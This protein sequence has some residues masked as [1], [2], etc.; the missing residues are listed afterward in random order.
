MH[1]VDSVVMSFLNWV[2][3]YFSLPVSEI[4]EFFL[5]LPLPKTAA[6][7][8]YKQRGEGKGEGGNILCKSSIHPS[9]QR[10]GCRNNLPS[11]QSWIS[12]L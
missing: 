2:S 11:S 4:L 6:S 9:M 1:I 7:M 5:S 12:L 10:L 8:W 3:H